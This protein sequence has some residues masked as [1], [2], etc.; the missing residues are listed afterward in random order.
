MD[1]N[2]G[3]FKGFDLQKLILQKKGRRKYDTAKTGKRKSNLETELDG[4]P[5]QTSLKFS[6]VT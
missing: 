1:L 3:I 4:S 2:S 6:H 5:L